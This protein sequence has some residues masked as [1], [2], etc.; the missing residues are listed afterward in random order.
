[1]ANWVARWH[2]RI[3]DYVVLSHLRSLVDILESQLVTQFTMSSD[4]GAAFWEFCV[5]FAP[6]Q[7][8]K[9]SASK[10]F[11]S[12][13][14]PLRIWKLN[15]QLSLQLLH[16]VAGLFLKSSTYKVLSASECHCGLCT[17]W[18]RCTGYL[19]FI[20]HVPHKSPIISGSFTERDLQLKAS[21]ASSPSCSVAL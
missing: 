10:S 1:M 9:K 5:A 2:L 14:G 6:G 7:F 18:R 8:S 4:C 13:F 16:S 21:H 17:G 15:L 19:I 11:C 20:D 12:I 3:S